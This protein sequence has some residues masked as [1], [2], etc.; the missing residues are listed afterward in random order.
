MKYIC[1]YF[2]KGKKIGC[3]D[4]PILHEP[5]YIPLKFGYNAADF[6]QNAQNRHPI[7][8]GWRDNGPHNCLLNRLSRRR[9]KKTSKLRVTGL[10]EGNSPL[11]GDFPPQR[12]SNAD[13]VSIWWRHHGSSERVRYG[14]SFV[15]SESDLCVA[16]V[17]A[18]LYVISYYIWPCNNGTRP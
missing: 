16:T 1:I 6:L 18:V 3:T 12:A 13:N 2:Y 7:A 9:S 14:V 17:I 10:C 4:Y 15:S 11:T 5:M 8:L